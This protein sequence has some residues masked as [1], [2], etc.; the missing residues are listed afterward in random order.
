MIAVYEAMV[1]GRGGPPVSVALL[2]GS[3]DPVFAEG[4]W[5]KRTFS[6]GAG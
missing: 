2:G 6:Q 4:Y 3:G 5:V 1:H